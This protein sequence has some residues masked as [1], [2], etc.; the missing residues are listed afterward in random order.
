MKPSISQKL[1]IKQIPQNKILWEI[2]VT[3]KLANIPTVFD[4]K[5]KIS[6]FKLRI[7]IVNGQQDGP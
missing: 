3:I 2:A 6:N 5:A 4:Q 1:L 7:Y